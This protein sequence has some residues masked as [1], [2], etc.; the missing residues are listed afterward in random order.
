MLRERR[1]TASHRK[2]NMTTDTW[3]IALAALAIGAVLGGWTATHIARLRLRAQV[4]RAT[5]AVRH[6]YNA[7]AE[8]QRSAQVRAKTELEQ[9]RV[10]F[11]RQLDSAAAEPRAAAL[12]AE[13]RLKQAYAEIDRLRDSIIGPEP[14]PLR[15]PPDGFAS[16]Q[17]MIT[18]Y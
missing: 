15:E 16:T 6:Q 10:A 2:Q 7:A 13:E 9:A 3:L 18:G 11:K 14:E 17:P 1:A 12:R 4:K 5:D 8:S